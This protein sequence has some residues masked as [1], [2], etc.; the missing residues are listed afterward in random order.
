MSQYRS[1]LEII[2]DVLLAV[3]NGTDKPT[4]IFYAANLSYRL[5]QDVLNNLVQNGLLSER[6]IPGKK[7]TRKRYSITEKGL[8]IIRHLD[9]AKEIMNPI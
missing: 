8:N 5:G 4:G 6:E 1:R 3:Q 2:R 9:R 7:K